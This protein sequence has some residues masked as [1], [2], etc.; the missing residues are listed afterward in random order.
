MKIL[1]NSDKFINLKATLLEKSD[2]L[3]VDEIEIWE[4]LLKWC[5]AQQ[6]MINDPT[7]WSK[8]NDCKLAD[9][10]CKVYYCYNDTLP[11]DYFMIFWNV[12]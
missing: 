4:N 5:F 3:N 12:I 2:D 7:K 6:N 10:F 8:E 9:F 11:Q 1:F